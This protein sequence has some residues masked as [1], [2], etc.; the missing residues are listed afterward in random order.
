MVGLGHGELVAVTLGKTSQ[1][2]IEQKHNVH[3]NTEVWRSEEAL[4]LGQAT[5][6]DFL[7]MV[8]PSRGANDNRDVQIEAKVDVAH[9]LV[10]LA[11]VDGDI[12]LF[13]LF[14]AF[15]PFLGIVDGDDDFML[16]GEGG[17]LHLVT[18]FSVSNDCYFH[19]VDFLSQNFQNHQNLLFTRKVAN[20]LLSCGDAVVEPHLFMMD[21]LHV[22]WV[23]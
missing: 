19:V 23:L 5:L 18:H 7:E 12:G 14:E 3:P 15:L 2:L 21:V 16:V 6:L 4:P 20:R 22:L 17:F 11:E 8:L 1:L 9:H 13:E 10:G